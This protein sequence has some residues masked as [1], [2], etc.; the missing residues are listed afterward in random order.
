MF[1]ALK[2]LERMFYPFGYAVLDLHSA[3]INRNV[4]GQLIAASIQTKSA[5]E[6]GQLL[7]E[8]GKIACPKKS[9]SATKLLYKFADP[10]KSHH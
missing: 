10:L 5:K 8:L 4:Y 3:Q 7:R 2:G 9:S 1:S 6:S